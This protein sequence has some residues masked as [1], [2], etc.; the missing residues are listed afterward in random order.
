MKTVLLASFAA[1]ALAS[2]SAFAAD[3]PLKAPAPPPPAYS[4][5]GCYIDGGAG[6]GMWNQD[7]NSE[8]FPGLVATTTTQTMGGRGWYGQVGAGCDYQVTP[9]I[10]IGAFG[11]YNFMDLHGQ[12]EDFLTGINGQEKESGAWAAGGR[13]GY[14]VSPNLMTYING[15]WTEAHFDQLNF[16]TFTFGAAPTG[17]DIAATTYEGWFLGGGTET[18]LAGLLPG[19]PK[20]LFL[21]SEYRY[22]S[23]SSKDD[24]IVVTATGLPTGA[25][26]HVTKYVQTIGTSLVWK[27]N[28]VG[29]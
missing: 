18:S 13:I 23:F 26:E 4:W 22:S 19:L 28:W 27:F 25:A 9:S 14:I 1:V 12:F 21:R 29:H 20:G 3:M 15:G 2:G 24:P 10:L 16:N 8:T 11:D 17:T 7:N 5:T 6:Y